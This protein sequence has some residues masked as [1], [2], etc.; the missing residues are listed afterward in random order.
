[1]VPKE[2]QTFRIKCL[3]DVTNEFQEEMGKK[4]RSDFAL[5]RAMATQPLPQSLTQ[6]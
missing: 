4:R 6:I 1:M 3:S 2:A 5:K